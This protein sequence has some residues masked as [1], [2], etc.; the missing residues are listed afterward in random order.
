M[1]PDLPPPSNL[2]NK[3][4]V[5]IAGAYSKFIR[6]V[7]KPVTVSATAQNSFPAVPFPPACP[8]DSIIHGKPD[9]IYRVVP[10][11][12]DDHIRTGLKCCG[13]VGWRHGNGSAGACRAQRKKVIRNIRIQKNAVWKNRSARL[14]FYCCLT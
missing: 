11:I 4:T 2:K 6:A 7:R 9:F 10:P 8:L 1:T 3:I 14:N 13:K 12:Y 5:L